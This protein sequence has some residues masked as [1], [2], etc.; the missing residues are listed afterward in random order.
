MAGMGREIIS[1]EFM[2]NKYVF[3]SSEKLRT[4]DGRRAGTSTGGG[5]AG[6]ST[7]AAVASTD[8]V[9]GSTTT[10]S[11]GR[12]GWVAAERCS[13]GSRGTGT[14]ALLPRRPELR[15]CG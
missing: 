7:A 2:Y 10:T 13:R 14:R 5:N 12:L 4:S 15:L 3:Y 1:T 11:D 6:G 8:G 9:G